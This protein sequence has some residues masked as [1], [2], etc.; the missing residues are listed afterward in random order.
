MPLPS[1]TAPSSFSVSTTAHWWRDWSLVSRVWVCFPNAHWFVFI[2]FY[3]FFC[4]ALLFKYMI[5]T[6][7]YVI[8]TLSPMT[9]VSVLLLVRNGSHQSEVSPRNI[10]GLQWQSP[11]SSGS[12][13]S[14]AP[15]QFLPSYLCPPRPLPVGQGTSCHRGRR[16]AH[17]YS[18]GLHA[19]QDL[20]L[21]PSQSHPYSQEVS[22]RQA[23]RGK[24][25]GS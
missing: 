19:V 5:C 1:P 25:M 22:G 23:D 3:D 8:Y 16:L 4:F 17:L 18:H 12:S 11:G 13:G 20:L 14:T 2:V 15:R 7:L 10:L 21:V 9:L 6:Y 24:S